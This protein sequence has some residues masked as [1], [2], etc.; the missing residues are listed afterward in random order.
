MTGSCQRMRK[1]MLVLAMSLAVI[2]A[3]AASSM[4]HFQMILQRRLTPWTWQDP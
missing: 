3:Y 1:L 4:A 2:V